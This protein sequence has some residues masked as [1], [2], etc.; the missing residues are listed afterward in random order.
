[1]PKFIVNAEETELF[2]LFREYKELTLCKQ[3][4]EHHKRTNYCAIWKCNTDP[5]GFCYKGRKYGKAD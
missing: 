3:C 5:E 1:M 4:E 2:F